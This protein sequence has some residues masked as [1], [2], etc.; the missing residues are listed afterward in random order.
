MG[1]A[2][3]EPRQCGEMAGRPLEAMVLVGLG[4]R[5]ISM[6]PAAIGPVKSMILALHK[7]EFSA[8]LEPMLNRPQHS[9][10]PEIE[11]FAR[12]RGIPL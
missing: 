5:S 11:R 4:Y 10:R 3:A 8:F 2:G 1:R 6:A 7:R 9:L 12:E